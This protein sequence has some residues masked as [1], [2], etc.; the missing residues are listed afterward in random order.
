MQSRGSG[1]GRRDTYERA[2]AMY[3]FHGNQACNTSL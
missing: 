3:D 1:V 2:K